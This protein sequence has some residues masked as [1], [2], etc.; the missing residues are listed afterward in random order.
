MAVTNTRPVLLRTD[1]SL[2]HTSGA[3]WFTDTQ[4]DI[5]RQAPMWKCPYCSKT[6][7][8]E[9]ETCYGGCGAPKPLEL[10]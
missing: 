3:F 1:M 4:L 7:K 6:H 9:I 10:Y 5:A 2:S 8:R